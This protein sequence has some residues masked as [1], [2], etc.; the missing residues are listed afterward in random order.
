[1]KL[2]HKIIYIYLRIKVF[3][4]MRKKKWKKISIIENPIGNLQDLENLKNDLANFEFTD[5]TEK[6]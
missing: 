3:F 1:M 4:E 6:S 5:R 2:K